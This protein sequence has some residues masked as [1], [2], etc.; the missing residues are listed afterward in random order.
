MNGRAA[1]LGLCCLFLL[2]A[3]MTTALKPVSDP[4]FTGLEQDDV[5]LRKRS[6]EQAT[7][8]NESGFL[9]NDAALESYL[10]AVARKIEPASVYEQIP[11]TVK[12]LRDPSLNAFALPNGS[13]YLHTGILASME[14]EAQLAALLGHEMT[15][16]TNRHAVRQV[17]DVK[18][19]SNVFTALFMATGGLA[20][21]FGPVARA[22]VMGYSRDLEREA[23]VDGFRL[24]SQAGYDAAESIKLFEALKRQI[25]EEKIQ[26]SYFFG[27]HPRIMERI[28]SYQGL[29]SAGTGTGPSRARNTE[30][31]QA[32]VKKLILDNAGLQ[33]QAGRY[34]RSVSALTRYIER[35]PAEADAWFLLGEANR[36]HGDGEHAKKAEEAYQKALGLDANY[37]EAH[38][39]LGILYL[40]TGNKSGAREHLERYLA[41]NAKAPDRAY[42]EGYIRECGQK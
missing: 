10:N 41:V 23:D 11:F 32:A 14:N 21:V 6:A 26:E 17:R 27:S 39:K 24:A 28:E 22:S 25:E 9:Y 1:I 3:C 13:V 36:Q 20:G 40:K 15:H 35:Y 19:K 5:S 31:F 16:A 18:N 33:M 42:I 4:G 30:A 29:I 12:V 34:E 37:A 7:Q 38:K 8:I 2:S